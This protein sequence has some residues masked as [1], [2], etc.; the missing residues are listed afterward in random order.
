[1]LLVVLHFII[2][3]ISTSSDIFGSTIYVIIDVEEVGKS[4]TT[5]KLSLILYHLLLVVCPKV[6]YE[7]PKRPL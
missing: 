5:M 4:V 3:T 6:V 2:F 1:M 7:P